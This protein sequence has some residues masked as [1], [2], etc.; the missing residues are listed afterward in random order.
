MTIA[1]VTGAAGGIGGAIV[2]VLR[3][4][5]WQVAGLD[6]QPGGADLDLIVDLAD[7]AALDLSVITDRLGAP[8]ALVNAAGLYQATNL[9]ETTPRTRRACSRSTSRRRSSSAANSSAS[10][11]L[12]GPRARSSTSPRSS[13]IPAARIRRTARRR[14][15]WSV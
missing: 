14:V 1:I 12:T 5:G 15:R 4:A 6:L 2:D 8:T 7:P 3:T 13:R 10:I 9:L 11:S